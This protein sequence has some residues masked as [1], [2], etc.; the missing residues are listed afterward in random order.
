ML[1][2]S[3][4]PKKLAAALRISFARRSSATSF[5]KA[6]IC[7]CAA[8]VTPG[9]APPSISTRRTHLRSVSADPIPA[10]QP[11][12]LIASNSDA[13]S[14]SVSSTTRTARSRNSGGYDEGHPVTWTLPTNPVP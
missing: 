13:W 11:S 9:L 8:V 2:S 7:S 5:L 1:R 6:L 3:S 14:A 10:W 4:A 12:D